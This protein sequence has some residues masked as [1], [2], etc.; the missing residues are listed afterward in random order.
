[1][2]KYVRNIKD[3]L[4]FIR[5]FLLAK[6]FSGLYKTLS[7]FSL[8]TSWV[9]KTNKDKSL[10]INDFYIPGRDFDRRYKL[11]DAIGKA[12]KLDNAKINY[13]EF[14]VAS[15]NSFKWW[16]N[17]NKNAESSFS[18][19]DTFEGLPESWGGYK[20]GDMSFNIPDITDKR[21]G[22]YKGLFQQTLNAFL[23]RS[24]SSFASSLTMV[25]LD[26]DLFSSTIYV[27][28]QLHKYLKKGDIILFDEFSV[29]NHEFLAYKIYTESFGVKLK[30]LGAVNNFFQV[31]FMIEEIH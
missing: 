5:V 28:S 17:F 23:D 27:L 1:M 4:L 9:N 7:N 3:F 19:F 18:G 15:G 24:S 31:A 12:L 10:V 30:P 11:Y 26:A 20:K 13:V 14:G 2:I 16:I 8:L 29:P 6:P 21:A 25:H 22:F